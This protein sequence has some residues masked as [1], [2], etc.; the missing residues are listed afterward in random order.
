MQLMVWL[1]RSICLNAWVE[2]NAYANLGA[3]AN[4]AYHDAYRRFVGVTLPDGDY[5]GNRDMF[6]TAPLYVESYLYANM[7]AAQFRDAMRS[8]FGVKDLTNEPRVAAWLTKYVY[9]DGAL[10]PWKTKVQRATGQPL[11]IDALVAYLTW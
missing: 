1:R 5:F 6:A 9:A 8:A 3:D 11:K 2:L 4:T 7:I 10:V